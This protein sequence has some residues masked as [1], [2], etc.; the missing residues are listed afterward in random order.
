MDAYTILLTLHNILRWIVLIAGIAASG[1]ALIGWLG[2]RPW[3][4]LDDRLGLLY[5]VSFDVQV[6]L[7]LILYL[8]VSPITTESFSD[9]GGAMG[10]DLARF[11]LIEHI[12]VMIIALVLAHVGRALSRR[13]EGDR[14]KHQR[15]AIFYTLSL[16]AVLAL[17]PWDR[18][19]LRL[20]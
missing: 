4:S 14:K 2:N 16:V 17:I 1:L 7:G 10:N 6:L 9:F 20:G 11:Y 5:T 18:P 3:T 15:A 19:L 8:F 12:A 13:A